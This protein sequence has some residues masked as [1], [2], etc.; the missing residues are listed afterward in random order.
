MI[1]KLNI[2]IENKLTKKIKYFLRL[3][4]G[5]WYIDEYDSKNNIIYY[6]S[7][8]GFWYKK[9]YDNEGNRIYYETSEGF[10]RDDRKN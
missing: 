3:D 10:I 4:S 6:E 2:T 8:R 7:S 9:E 5:Y 1:D